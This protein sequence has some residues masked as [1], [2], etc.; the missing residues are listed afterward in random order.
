MKVILK[1]TDLTFQSQK[2]WVYTLIDTVNVNN[3]ER[4]NWCNVGVEAG[5]HYKAVI[6]NFSSDSSTGLTVRSMNVKSLSGVDIAETFKSNIKANETFEFD[7]T[8]DAPFISLFW[9]TAA[10]NPAT[11]TFK[12]YKGA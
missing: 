10:T 2:K 11:F 3:A 12:L 5:A 6:T 8:K 1:N 4:A 9:G 7:S